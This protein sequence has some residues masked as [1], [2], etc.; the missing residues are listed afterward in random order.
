MPESDRKAKNDGSSL[1]AI[2]N[3]QEELKVQQ[4][5][6]LTNGVINSC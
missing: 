3:R 5:T 1:E 6:G 2:A 4:A